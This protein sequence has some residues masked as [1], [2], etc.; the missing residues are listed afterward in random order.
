[1]PEVQIAV[2]FHSGYGH[3]ARQAEAVARGAENAGAR[4]SLHDVTAPDAD[5]WSALD[6]AHAIVFGSPTYMGGTSAAFQAFAEA[7]GPVWQRR[8]WQG[9]LAAGFTNSAGIN[10]NKDTTLSALAVFA[11][12]HGMVWVPLGL[13]PG[14][15]YSSAGDRDDL[16]RLAGF[17]GAMAQSPADLGPDRAPSDGDLRT[18]EHLGAQVARTALRFEHGRA[19]VTA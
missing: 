17:T 2:A 15:E 16:N 7:T 3:T 13:L 8:G 4:V 1:M 19:A 18:A 10:G 9:K 5:L 14:G 11:A 6:A 12:Q